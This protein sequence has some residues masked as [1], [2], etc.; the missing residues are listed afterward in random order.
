M[1]LTKFLHAKHENER[2]EIVKSPARDRFTIRAG[3]PAFTLIEL[4]VVIAIIAILAAI[5]LPVLQ[6]AK[7]RALVIECINNK[8]QLAIA[9]TMYPNDFNDYLI[10]NALL[11]PISD[12]GWCC[13]ANGENWTTSTENI[14]PL[15]YTTNCLADYLSKQ[16]KVYKCPADNIPSS[17]GDRLRSVSMN[18][19]IIGGLPGVGNYW[20]SGPANPSTVSA[21]YNYNPSWPLYTKTSQLLGIK[22]VDIWVFTDESMFALDDG[23]LQLAMNSPGFPNIPANY[24][25]KGSTFCFQDGHVEEHK[26]HATCIST[27]YAFN[28][29]HF[30]DGGNWAPGGGGKQVP[31]NDQDYLW[32]TMHS[33]SKS[34]FP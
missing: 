30:N 3:I 18:G 17:N 28:V 2:G 26:W 8:K 25:A 29:N 4:L 20:L 23:Y 19:M 16:I 31:A 6:Q 13:S 15:S 9:C 12:Y 14:N 1:R 33:A 22:P 27:P 11:G 10:P 34:D 24:H 7:V 5:L 21:E 32:L